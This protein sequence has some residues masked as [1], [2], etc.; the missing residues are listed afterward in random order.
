MSRRY[1]SA[2]S[3]R[4]AMNWWPPY[5]F[6]G[7]R[8]LKLSDDW[9]S[10]RVGLRLHF[11]NRN[12]VG[13]QFGGSLFSMGDPFWMLLVMNNLGRDYIVWD[14]AG[15]IDF[16]SPGRG[17]VHADFELTEDRLEEIRQATADGAKAL[18]WFEHEVVAE[19]GTVVARVRKQL[20]V[21]LKQGRSAGGAGTPGD[22]AVPAVAGSQPGRPGLTNPES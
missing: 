10:A 4:R 5:L 22:R 3:L 16:V 11:L 12:Y 7:V 20:Y 19:D 6:S 13:T 18:P 15:E 8:V 17:P 21:R 9:R 14:K 1:Y 2:K